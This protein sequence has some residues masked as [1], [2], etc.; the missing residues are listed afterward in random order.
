MINHRNDVIKLAALC[1]A[2]SIEC[3]IATDL[4]CSRSGNFGR[5][6]PYWTKRLHHACN[7]P[8]LT[9]SMRVIQ[10]CW[11]SGCVGELARR[12]NRGRGR[13]NNPHAK[14]ATTE[15]GVKPGFGHILT[16]LAEICFL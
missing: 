16:A 12:L 10:T 7:R 8:C 14:R 6:T 11:Y 5:V 13:A 1:L 15:E 9:K 2:L 4:L 3:C